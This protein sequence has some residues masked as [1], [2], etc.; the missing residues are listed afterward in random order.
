MIK[1]EYYAKNKV[2]FNYFIDCFYIIH[3]LI[4][5]PD[6]RFLVV[7]VPVSD[8]CNYKKTNNFDEL[9]KKLLIEYV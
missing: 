7:Y 6:E 5:Q 3:S 9:H 2:Y 1:E 4:N 8:L